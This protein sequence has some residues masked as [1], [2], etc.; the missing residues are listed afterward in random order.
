MMAR[1]V[2]SRIYGIFFGNFWLKLLA[3]AI[4]AFA[5]APVL[6]ARIEAEMNARLGRSLTAAS[7]H[8][9]IWPTPQITLSDVTVAG[10]SAMAEPAL[11]AK[12][13]TVPVSIPTLE[14]LA[15]RK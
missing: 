8:F 7:A 5:T 13:F 1:T 9:S 14:V 10:I 6:A 2:P 11:T 4:A 3:L 12:T 15:A